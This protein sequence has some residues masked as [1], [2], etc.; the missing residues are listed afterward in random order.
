MVRR[1]VAHEPV[2]YILGR[3]GFRRIELRTDRR[4][5]IPRPETELL[6][7]VALELVPRRV[8]DVG[9]GSG[10]IALAVADELPG[11]EVV[12]VDVA[13]DA[14]DL[15]RENA[16]ALGLADRVSFREGT[17]TAAAGAVRPR[18]SRTSPTS[19]HG[20]RQLL[21]PDITGYEPDRGAVRRARRARRS[22]PRCSP[23]WRR[24]AAARPAT[25]SRSRSAPGRRRRFAGS[26]T[27]RGS[28]PSIPRAD[29]AGIERGRRSER[30]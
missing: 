8:L 17:V 1:R 22:S 24:A 29:L 6:V 26:S 3:R 21:P 11:A 18:R 4:A 30:R 10:A 19:A 12:A 27:M 20:E 28:P 15:A 14:L 5:L 16:A 13:A 2:A 23:R 7:D 9:T 25:P